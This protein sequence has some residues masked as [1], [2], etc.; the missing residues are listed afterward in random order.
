MARFKIAM[1]TWSCQGHVAS[2]DGTV[3]F[4]SATL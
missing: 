1:P 4:F 2:R 3:K